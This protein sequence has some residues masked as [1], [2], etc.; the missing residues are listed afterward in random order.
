M[1]SNNGNSAGVGTGSIHLKQWAS[2]LGASGVGL[3]AMGAH[4]LK[5][6]FDKKPGSVEHWK[7]AVAYQLFHAV[8][9]IGIGALHE[10]QLSTSSNK[11]RQSSPL[12]TY[13]LAGQIMAMGSLFFSGSIYLLVLDIGPKKLLGPVTPIGGLLLIAGWTVLGCV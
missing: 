10:N 12:C 8:A 2:L 5:K 7:T 11:I 6:T 4:A 1:T 9:I 3:G 13:Q